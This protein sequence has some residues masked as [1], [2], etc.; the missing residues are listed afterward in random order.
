MADILPSLFPSLFQ[1]LLGSTLSKFALQERMEI[2]EHLT[3]FNRSDVS[4]ENITK[5]FESTSVDHV[6]DLRSFLFSVAAEKGLT[7]VCHSLV[8]RN[9]DENMKNKL[10]KDIH[11]LTTCIKRLEPVPCSLQ[12]FYSMKDAIHCKLQVSLLYTF[13]T[14]HIL[15]SYFCSQID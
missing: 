11:V 5:R 14:L 8:E 6:A 1:N 13:L 3:G 2:L 9:M 12:A 4:M 7:K 10:F 15:W